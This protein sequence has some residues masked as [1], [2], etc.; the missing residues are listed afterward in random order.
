MFDVRRLRVL[1][2]VVRRGS[3]SAAAAALSYTTSAISQQVSALERELGVPLLVRGPTGARPTPAGTELLAHAGTLLGVVG[4]AERA[5]AAFAPGG[6]GAVRVA[7]FGGATTMILSRAAMRLRA[8]F[9]DV[10]V[11]FVTADPDDGVA[12]ISDGKADLALITQVPGERPRYPHVVSMPVYDE[13]FYVVLPRRHRYAGAADVPL[14]ALARERW[15]ISSA[16]GRCTDTR[17]FRGACRRAGFVPTVTFRAEDHP[18]VQGMVA[19]G[20]GVSLVPCLAASGSPADVAVRRVAGTRP[21]RRIG[22]AIT[23]TPEPRSAL[24]AFVGLIRTE[25]ERLRETVP[26]QQ[27]R[28]YHVAQ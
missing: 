3:L 26:A 6:S 22:L 12:L 28:A 17:V 9:P 10:P 4:A 27:V 5:V 19:A 14:T 15:I 13:E 23:A 21:A 20:M 16:T 11:E 18:T 1:D 24:A 8:E 7:S 25:G 2:E